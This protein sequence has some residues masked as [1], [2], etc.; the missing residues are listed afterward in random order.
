MKLRKLY[1]GIKKG[2]KI[3]KVKNLE[4]LGTDYGGWIIP[5]ELIDVYSICYCVGAGEDISFDCELADRFGCR[6]YIFDPT[7]RA[8]KHFQEFKKT[9]LQGKKMKINNIDNLY[10]NIDSEKLPLLHYFDYGIWSKTGVKKFFVPKNSKHISHSI[11]NLQKTNKYFEAECKSLSQ[12]M[13]RLN[14]KKLDLLKLDIEGAEH[15]V[16]KS[17]V[18]DD[19]DIKLICVEFDEKKK[20]QNT[21]K[22]L[23]KHNYIM[24]A[25]KGESDYTFL[26]KDIYEQFI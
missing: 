24:I 6:V 13:K 19:L 18:Q 9:I 7:P 8:K 14:H 4:K 25:K 3:H 5:T 16:I 22:N 11:L 21:I 1:W 10:Y 2:F 23:L 26:R 20:M 17:L 15:E 12:I